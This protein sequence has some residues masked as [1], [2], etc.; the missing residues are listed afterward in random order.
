MNIFLATLKLSFGQFSHIVR[1]CLELS[2]IDVGLCCRHVR[3]S[4]GT[5]LHAVDPSDLFIPQSTMSHAP[6]LQV[7]QAQGP[8]LISPVFR[9]GPVSI[10][11][12]FSEILFG[13]V[14]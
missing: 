14:V 4:L 9:P 3:L 8:S 1:I 6:H 2:V 7:I 10:Q 5:I 11:F 12:R 13:M